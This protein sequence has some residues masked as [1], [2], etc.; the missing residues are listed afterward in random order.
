[1]AHRQG[2]A[3][4]HRL[5]KIINA[6]RRRAERV[7]PVQFVQQHQA[8]AGLKGKGA[9]PFAALM[10][11]EMM[12]FMLALSC[13]QH[14][15]ATGAMAPTTKAAFHLFHRDDFLIAVPDGERD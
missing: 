6:Q 1:M 13:Y 2:F 7:N 11:A 3:R 4:A 9:I 12:G 14:A 10:V 5:V 8:N 15:M